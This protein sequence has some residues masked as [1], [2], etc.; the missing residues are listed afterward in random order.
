LLLEIEIKYFNMIFEYS[1]RNKKVLIIT[2]LLLVL[3]GLSYL[4]WLNKEPKIRACTEEAKICPDGSVV[5]RTGPN[6]EFSEC[7]TEKSFG[8]E[9][10]EKS[11]INYLLSEKR[12]SWKTKE[13]SFNFCSIENLGEEKDLFPV[14]IWAYCSEYILENNNIRNVSGSSGPLEINY[15]NELS[16]YNISRFSYRAPRD[17]SYYGED[18]KEIFPKDV[19]EKIFNFDRNHIIQ[20]TEDLAMKNIISWESINKALNNCEVEEIFQA[21]SKEVSATLNNGDKIEAVEPQIDEIIKETTKAS[22]KCG[23]IRM[24]TE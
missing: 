18:V 16:Y 17:G 6:C 19:Q 13:N 21:H 5:V 7:P 1:Y 15:P 3:S 22:Q 4:T 20:K 10:I 9:H 11:I 14:Y 8:N 2:S 24:A 23:D 12:F